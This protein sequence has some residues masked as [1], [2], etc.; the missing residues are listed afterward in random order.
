MKNILSILTIA[1]TFL[2]SS[3]QK[4]EP[5]NVKFDVTTEKNEIAVSD[6]V[7]F[8]LQGNPDLISFYSGEPGK[9][10]KYRDR[11]FE[12]GSKLELTVAS[13]VLNGS[14]ADNVKL[15]YS[16][17]FS[18]IYSAAGIKNEEWTD[19]SNKFTWSVS[20]GTN[21]S[22][23]DYTT[24]A[25]VDITDLLV[26]DKP[27]YFGFKYESQAAASNALGGKTWRIPRFDLVNISKDGVRT[28]IATVHTAGFTSIPII[29]S[30]DPTQ[31]WVFA[32]NS[33]TDRFL[34]FVPSKR[35]EAHLYWAVSSS[36]LPGTVTPD[37][38]KT[39]KAYLDEMKSTYKYKFSRPGTYIVTFIAKNANGKGSKEVVKEIE[40]V[41]K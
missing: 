35:S 26:K 7:T 11:I 4:D 18:G 34:T 38:S 31:A 13:R 41:V 32:Q 23:A 9:E 12:E 8:N 1:T 39:I 16:N 19:I 15:L 22:A 36:F 27:I 24:S 6:S 20:P 25:P 2:F 3:C 17:S 40:I 10:Y 14:Q 5:E 28:T 29:A 30:T 37:K 21:T 33:A